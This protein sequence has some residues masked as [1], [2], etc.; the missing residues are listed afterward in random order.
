MPVEGIRQYLLSKVG[1]DLSLYSRAHVDKSISERMAVLGVQEL[2]GY[3]HF[4]K[5]Q[6]EEPVALLDSVLINVSSFF[7]DPLVFELLNRRV[8]PQLAG[9]CVVEPCA[10][11]RIWSA[12]CAGGEEPYS[13]AILIRQLQETRYPRLRAHLFATDMDRTALDTAARARYP[14]ESLTEVR[15]GLL[16]RY[17]VPEGEAYR[18]RDEI[19]SM[20]RFSQHNLT[21]QEG[22]APPDSVFGSFDLILCR[23]VLIHISREAQVLVLRSLGQALAS[24]G[25]LVLGPAEA[26][27]VQS[28][29]GMT[30]ISRTCHIWQKLGDCND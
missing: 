6:D 8:L 21:S 15:V 9:R 19:V 11:L 1:V 14:R 18:L 24:G 23:N 4:L 29:T 3:Y 26:S 10:R 20:V 12:G 30:R 22:S 27:N 28:L 2:T 7:R 16:D 25:Y 13:L 17:F 5:Q